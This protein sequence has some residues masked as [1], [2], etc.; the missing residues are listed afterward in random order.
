MQS[1]CL[2]SGRQSL[3]WSGEQPPRRLTPTG[4]FVHSS[5]MRI[6]VL[7]EG[8]RKEVRRHA[9]MVEKT[10]RERA[11]ERESKLNSLIDIGEEEA[12]AQVDPVWLWE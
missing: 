3:S 8:W 5:K 10:L 7:D 6:K 11:R 4:L 12:K 9:E 2:R 1:G